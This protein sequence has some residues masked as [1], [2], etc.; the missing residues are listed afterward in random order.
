VCAHILTKFNNLR[1]LEFYPYCDIYID[2]VERLSFQLLE[3]PTFFSSSLTTLHIN[4]EDFTDCLY[5]LDGRLKQLHSFYVDVH[6][7]WPPSSTI[8][9]QVDYFSLKK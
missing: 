1:C 5:L 9:S 7:F 8:F 2:D 6:L 3:P 4:V